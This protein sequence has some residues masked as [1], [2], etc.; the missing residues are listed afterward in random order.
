MTESFNNWNQTE[1][2]SES[3]TAYAMNNSTEIYEL[4]SKIAHT[5]SW[6]ELVSI[7]Q[8]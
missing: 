1:K 2:I 5:P 6:L 3:Q 7:A 8:W 4:S